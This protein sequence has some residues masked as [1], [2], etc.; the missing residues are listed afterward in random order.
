MGEKYLT[1]SMRICGRTEDGSSRGCKLPP[2]TAFSCLPEVHTCNTGVRL[3]S[4]PKHLEKTRIT[5]DFAFPASTRDF[6]SIS[7]IQWLVFF[8]TSHSHDCSYPCS[9]VWN[10][11]LQGTLS[12]QMQKPCLYLTASAGQQAVHGHT[13]LIYVLKCGFRACKPRE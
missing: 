4:Q 2:S 3:L 8:Q 6:F 11:S 12:T 9:H 10:R 7:S 13:L 1:H 5:R